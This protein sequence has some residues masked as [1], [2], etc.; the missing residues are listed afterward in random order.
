[1]KKRSN[2]PVFLLDEI[3]KIGDD[4]RGDLASALL[5]VLDLEQNYSLVI[6]ITA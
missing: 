4:L 5:E 3:D 6:V 2:N 1:M